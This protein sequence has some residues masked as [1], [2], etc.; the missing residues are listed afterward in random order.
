MKVSKGVLGSELIWYLRD[1]ERGGIFREQVDDM[2]KAIASV[3]CD[4]K[5]EYFLSLRKLAVNGKTYLQT[6]EN[7]CRR[8]DDLAVVLVKLQRRDQA[9]L[10][11]STTT[12]MQ[13]DAVLDILRRA[14]FD[15]LLSIRSL[16]FLDFQSYSEAYM[17]HALTPY[18]PITFSPVQP[19]VDFLDAAAKLQGSVAAFGSRVQIQ[20]RRFVI[21]TLGNATDAT[22]LRA[23]LGAGQSV[24][25]SLR[26]DQNIFNGFSRIRVSRVRCYLDG[27]KTVCPPTGMDTLRLYLKTPGRFSDIALPG[28]RTDRV[29]NFVGDARALLF[30]YVPLDGSIVCDGEYSQQRD[31]TLQTPLTEWEVC[32]APGGLE[33]KDLDL[34]ELTGLRMEF[35]CDVTLGDL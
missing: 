8:G 30:E 2:E 9:R 18:P 13:Q 5:R 1:N 10:T 21:R 6:Q 23:Q 11:L 14:M 29:S 34:E 3:D 19:V 22:D 33:V 32:I 15:R 31:C 20:N 16:I 12:L 4:G 17:F 35:W 28:A 7:L 24:T 25:V 26:P 27:V